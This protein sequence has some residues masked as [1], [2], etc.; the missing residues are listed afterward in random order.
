MRGGAF[1]ALGPHLH[2]AAQYHPEAQGLAGRGAGH[3]LSPHTQAPLLHLG[4]SSPQFGEIVEQPEQVQPPAEQAGSDG[5][6]QAGREESGHGG[7]R[8]R[9]TPPMQVGSDGLGQAGREESGHGGFTCGIRQRHTPPMQ[10]GSDGL[11]Q[12]GRR[13]VRAWRIYMR[14]STAPHASDAGRFRRAGAGWSRRVR[15]AP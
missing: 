1:D 15:A 10:V 11:G 14:N 6:G 3:P 9:H 13:R 7:I 8:Q 4:A 12:A 5:L 2:P